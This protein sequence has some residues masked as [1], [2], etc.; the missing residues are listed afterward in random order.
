MPEDRCFK[1]KNLLNGMKPIFKHVFPKKVTDNTFHV[2]D[3]MI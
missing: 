2:A 1:K 3:A